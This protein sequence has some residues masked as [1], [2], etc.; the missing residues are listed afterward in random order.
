MRLCDFRKFSIMFVLAVALTLAVA[1]SPKE[2]F[3]K[4]VAFSASGRSLEARITSSES[5]KFTYFELDDPHRLVVDFHGLR[6]GIA[7]T[8]KNIAAAGVTR[9]RTSHFQAPDRSA[10]RIVFDLDKTVNYHVI[11]DGAGVV[12]VV[13]DA[14]GIL[15]QL[16]VQAPLNLIAGP[17]VLSKEETT[18]ALPKVRLESLSTVK[19]AGV[20]E[21]LPV[22]APGAAAAAAAEAAAEAAATPAAAPAP[23]APAAPPALTATPSQAAPAPAPG[24]AAPAPAPAQAAPAQ[25][26]GQAAPQPQQLSS[27]I[28]VSTQAQGPAVTGP[29]EPQTFN[30]ELIDLD[31]KQADL[32]D[33]FRLVADMSGLNVVVDQ[34]VTGSVTVTLKEVPWDQALDIVLRNHNLGGILEGRNVLRIATRAT[35]QSEDAARRAQRDAAL[36]AVPPVSKSYVLSY[37]KAAD[38]AATLLQSR[39]VSSRGTVATEPRRNAII[40]TDVAE[41]FEGIEKLIQFMDTPA[42]QVEIEA[43]LLSANKSFS[44]EFGS[45][46]AL[47]VGAND[48]NVLTG[49]QGESSPFARTPPPRVTVG[50]AGLPLL[51]NLPAAATSGVAFLLQPGSDILLDAI[52]TAAEASGNAR[53]LSQPKVTTESNVKAEI[54]QGTKIPVQTNVNNTITTTFLTFALRLEVT[55]QVTEDGTVVLEV[56]IENSQPDLARTVNGVPVVGTQHARTRRTVPDGAT[57]MLG[58]IFVDTDS[59]NVRQVPGLGSI[60]IIGHLFKNT[61]TIKSQAELF[62][63]ITPRIKK[64][65]AVAAEAPRNN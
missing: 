23:V 59:L 22:A 4:D 25:A 6:N 57:M 44:R 15:D 10:T 33:F 16:D 9:V 65:D 55:P 61:Q 1:A 27:R 11:D 36:A 39:M 35:L 38:V 48:G 24:Q 40:V 17:P 41:Q 56:D 26:P 63:F 62:F 28:S 42:Q 50:G 46:L 64:A 37:P 53:L 7:F 21:P 47:L 2:A 18:P 19:V 8:Q 60:P 31:L 30:G 34:N 54:E 49:G 32:G 20:Q 51:T 5:A 14:P 43:R 29:A 45:Q 12:R 3:V 58:G 13:F 52:I